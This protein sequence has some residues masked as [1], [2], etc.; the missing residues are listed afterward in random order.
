V[1]PV[2]PHRLL[3]SLVRGLIATY[4]SYL[5]QCPVPNTLLRP[6]RWSD[7]AG[8]NLFFLHPNNLASSKAH[9]PLAPSAQNPASHK[10][11]S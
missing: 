7:C 3:A 5:A 4:T 11:N 9:H 2:R 6:D 10:N 1:H 8:P